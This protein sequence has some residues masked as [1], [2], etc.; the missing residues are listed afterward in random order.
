MTWNS[1]V[2][3][4]PNIVCLQPAI[5]SCIS[6]PAWQPSECKGQWLTM[7]MNVDA[8]KQW[9]QLVGCHKMVV[10]SICLFMLTSQ[11]GLAQHLDPKATE[12]YAILVKI[13]DAYRQHVP[14]NVSDRQTK[15]GKDICDNLDLIGV[16]T[17]MPIPELTGFRDETKRI[18]W[19]LAELHEHHLIFVFKNADRPQ[20][21]DLKCKATFFFEHGLWK[22]HD[23]LLN[24]RDGRSEYVSSKSPD[25]L[26]KALGIAAIDFV[27]SAAKA[28]MNIPPNN[29]SAIH[30]KIADFQEAARNNG[31]EYRREVAEFKSAAIEWEAFST[32]WNQIIEQSNA[33][34]SSTNQTKQFTARV[35]AEDEAKSHAEAKVTGAGVE[36]ENRFTAGGEAN[37]LLTEKTA[38]D[39]AGSTKNTIRPL[40]MQASEDYQKI[41]T[42]LHAAYDSILNM[43]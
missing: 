3:V 7:N 35:H 32:Q 41:S 18:Y 12:E 31:L 42:K 19:G 26:K 11:T 2:T 34:N 17:N 14:E 13:V 22:F 4:R 1:S 39:I 9:Y 33:I 28:V 5:F 30:N 20:L 24:Y 6:F 21:D 16:L 10:Q 8:L 27:K 25:E 40:S 38:S 43:K 36:S 37:I 23:I 15:I 29:F